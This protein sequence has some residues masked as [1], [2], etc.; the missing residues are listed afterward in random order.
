MHYDRIEVSERIDLN[1]TRE[2][3]ECDIFHYWYVLYK[4]FKFQSYF[5]NSPHN[6][7]MVSMNLNDNDI[8][9]I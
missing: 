3:K 6:L 4:G 2:S 1:K 7:L 8:V 5:C 9:N